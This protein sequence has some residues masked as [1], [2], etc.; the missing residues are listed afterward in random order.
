MDPVLT[1]SATALARA[2]AR[3]ERSS[4]EVMDAHI[5]RIIETAPRLNALVHDRFSAAREEAKEADRTVEAGAPLGPLHGVPVT[6][7]ECL[8]VAGLRKTAGLVARAHTV[9]ERDATSAARLRAAGAIV[10]GVSNVS[11]LMMWME[12]DNKVYGRTNNPYDATRTPGGSSGGEGALVGAGCSP[13]GIGSDIGGSIRMPAFFSGVFGHKPSPGL[14]PNTGHWPMAEGPA[15]RFLGTGPL[16][17]RAEDLFPVLKLIA[18]PDGQ[19]RAC[20]PMALGDPADVDLSKLT[21]Y[22]VRSTGAF[23]VSPELAEAQ[24]RAADHLASR[25]C[26]V[27]RYEHPLFARAFF[28]WSRLMTDAAKTK[29][30][31]NLANGGELAFARELVALLR[32]RSTHTLPALALAGAERIAHLIP[33]SAR[34]YAEVER[35]K[36]DL[37]ALL[38]ERAALLYPSYPTLAPK[39]SHALLPPLKWQYTALWNVLE[40]PVTQAPLGLAGGLPTGIQIVGGLGRDHVTI[41]VAQALEQLGGWVPPP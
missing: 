24:A 13:V 27:V 23:T 7:K 14:V 39:H 41:A 26:N 12:T 21:I 11:E 35:L 19:D 40:L 16:C 8:G 25:G 20:E 6:I 15:Q 34:D 4:R 29:L 36:G 37:R 17:R 30:G 9:A 31:T 10:L 5:A 38:D 28:L 32:G 3:R 2:I 22:D 33:N 18:G 1:M